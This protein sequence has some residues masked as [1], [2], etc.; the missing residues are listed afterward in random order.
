MSH[1]P[2]VA[3]IGL[4]LHPTTAVDR[5]IGTITDWARAHGSTVL[6]RAA[7]VTPV[8]PMAGIDRSVVLGA[9]SLVP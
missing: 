3:T 9:G 5:S 1:D 6:V 7:D 4:V 2:G 8:A